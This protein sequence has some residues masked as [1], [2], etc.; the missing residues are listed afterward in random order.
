MP[1]GVLRPSGGKATHIKRIRQ[2][3]RLDDV[4]LY[5]STNIATSARG[6]YWENDAK[7]LDAVDISR[8]PAVN[9]FPQGDVPQTTKLEASAPF[10][11]SPRSTR[12]TAGPRRRPGAAHLF[13]TDLRGCSGAYDR[14]RRRE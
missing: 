9:I 2:S 14:N 1:A 6:L 12:S 8:S 4:S 13:A 3:E 10:P 11:P 7:N 5:G